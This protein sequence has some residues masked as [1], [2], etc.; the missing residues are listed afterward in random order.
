MDV[1]MTEASSNMEKTIQEKI[2]YLLRKTNPLMSAELAEEFD[3]SIDVIERELNS[4]IQQEMVYRDGDVYYANT[5]Y[6]LDNIEKLQKETREI[7][8]N[9]KK[10]LKRLK[11]R[12]S[13]IE[14]KINNIY[15][16]L[17]SLMS[18]FVAIF[19]LIV[20]NANIT[21]KLTQEN[22]VGVF[23]GIIIT[24]LFVILCII[25]LLIGIKVLIINSLRKSP[26]E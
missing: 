13:E 6:R 3:T 14:S 9:Y 7:N 2:L 25:I 22:M 19:S 20:T 11:K 26:K 24:N 12:S 17:I 1:K 18:V 10:E 5:R 16:N 23:K 21:F 15:L 4:L 8:E